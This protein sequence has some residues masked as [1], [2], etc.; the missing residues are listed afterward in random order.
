MSIN[1]TKKRSKSV[2]NE[3]E[4]LEM[5]D[6]NVEYYKIANPIKIKA[7]KMKKIQ[8][9]EQ[10]GVNKNDCLNKGKQLIRNNSVDLYKKHMR[11]KKLKNND[12]NGFNINNN[13]NNNEKDGKQNK[14]VKFLGSKFVTIIE[15]ESYKKYNVENACKDPYEKFY[16]KNDTGNNCCVGNDKVVCS[17]FIV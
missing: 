8:F 6:N 14:Q 13:F 16:K 3:N 5:L 7:E 12:I 1:N 9:Y 4:I 15:V 2:M 10:M 11:E 17:C